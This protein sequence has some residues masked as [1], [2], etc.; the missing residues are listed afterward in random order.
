[1]TDVEHQRKVCSL[2]KICRIKVLHHIC[3][4]Q[5]LW[6]NVYP[7]AKKKTLSWKYIISTKLMK[8]IKYRNKNKRHQSIICD[9][10]LWLSSHSFLFQC[11]H[12]RLR[13]NDELLHWSGSTINGISPGEGRCSRVFL[14]HSYSSIIQAHSPLFWSE[15]SYTDVSC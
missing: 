12:Y 13:C 15:N 3:S 9:W 14:H 7:K 5:K 4:L 10:Y 6:G 8:L 1:M 11:Q 2:M